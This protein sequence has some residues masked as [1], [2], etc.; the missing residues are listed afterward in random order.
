MQ[1]LKIEKDTIFA[2]NDFSFMVFD[3]NS[4]ISSTKDTIIG[5]S[6]AIPSGIESASKPESIQVIKSGSNY[7]NMLNMT[8][9]SSLSSAMDKIAKEKD[10]PE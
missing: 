9:L 1:I 3:R 6:W 7:H 2:F 4:I 5:Y 10:S 8:L